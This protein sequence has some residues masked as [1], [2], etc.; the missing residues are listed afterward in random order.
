[1]ITIVVQIGNTDN[2][3]SQELWAKYVHR[4]HTLME[5]ELLHFF[6]GP[7]N[8]EYWQNAC[9]VIE[10]TKDRESKIIYKLIEIRKVFNQDSIAITVGE[11]KFV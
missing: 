1:M 8:Y 3:L 9:W 4:V 7:P 5:M 10:T 6:G 2:K 11:T